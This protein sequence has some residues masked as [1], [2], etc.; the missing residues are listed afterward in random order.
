MAA[1]EECI[2]EGFTRFIGVSNFSS[3][4]MKESQNYLENAKIAVNQVEYSL[5]DQKPRMEVLPT[6]REMGISIVAYRPIGRGA[7]AKSGNSV[8]DELTESYGKSRVQIALNWLIRQDNVFAIPKSSNPV[9][10]M[11]FIGAVG[12]RLSDEDA[13][14]LS[15]AFI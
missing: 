8:L 10:L 1:M 2:H 4:L 7:L 13:N 6:C 11:E 12:W 15:K 14:R 9:H 5:I 3:Q